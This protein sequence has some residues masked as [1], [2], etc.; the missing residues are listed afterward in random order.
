MEGS[1]APPTSRPL[2]SSTP[3]SHRTLHPTGSHT[4]KRTLTALI[5]TTPLVAASFASAGEL[6]LLG[7]VPYSYSTGAS[8]D[9][10]VVSG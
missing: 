9:G 10:T 5:A 3:T 2:I 1:A 6:F 8:A 4:M 7:A